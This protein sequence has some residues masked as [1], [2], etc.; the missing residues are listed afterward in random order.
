MN[1]AASVLAPVK[2]TGVPVSWVHWNVA[3]SPEEPTLFN[4]TGW[5]GMAVVGF[6]EAAAAT[7]TESKSK[8]TSRTG[9]VSEPPAEDLITT[10][11][12]GEASGVANVPSLPTTP[13]GMAVRVTPAA[14]LLR[15]PTVS[16]PVSRS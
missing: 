10:F 8:P 1:V 14:T 6:A 4:S 9:S 3:M 13:P 11:N 7:T 5:P 2:V 15:A 12:G 16:L